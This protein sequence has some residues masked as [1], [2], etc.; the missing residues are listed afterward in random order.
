MPIA[1]LFNQRIVI[2]MAEETQDP[3]VEILERI[4]AANKKAKPEKRPVGRPSLYQPEYC[5]I[6]IELGKLGKSIAQ[7]ASAFDVD[8]ASI[9][10]WAAAHEDFST[11]LARAKV[12]SQNW[13]ENKAQGNMDNK[14]FNAQLWLKSVTSRF[15][16]D[17]TEKQVT[18]LTG[19]D[20]GAIKME[21]AHKID[22]DQLEPEQRDVLKTIFLTALKTADK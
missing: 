12:H 2:E 18:E 8:K 5:E 9:F 21:T 14:N 3:M 15:R 6:V 22:A 11:A 17:Y 4:A 13:W 10:D 16:D 7:M 20:G 1:H 19:A